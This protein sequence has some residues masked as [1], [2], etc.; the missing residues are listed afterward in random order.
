MYVKL[1]VGM[2]RARAQ[3][4]F[5]IVDAEGQKITSHEEL[6]WI[7]QYLLDGLAS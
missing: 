2:C 6:D 3:Y 7:R 4:A 1:V 5:Y